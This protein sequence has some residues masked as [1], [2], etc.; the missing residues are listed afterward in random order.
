MRMRDPEHV[1]ESAEIAQKLIL[2]L[3]E[4]DPNHETF[5]QVGLLDGLSIVKEYVEHGELGCALHHFLYMIHEADIEYPREIVLSLHKMADRIGEKIENHSSSGIIVSTGLGS[6]G[7][8][9]STLAG[10]TGVASVL[11]GRVLKI[12]ERKAV[13]WDADYLYFS[14]RKPWP[15]KMSGAGITFGK[16]TPSPPHHRL[17]DARERHHFQ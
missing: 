2:A 13:A 3:H 10:A 7:W 4:R 15:S 16:V 14:V 5:E 9:R 17:T 6:T 11:S 1:M 12:N 8:L